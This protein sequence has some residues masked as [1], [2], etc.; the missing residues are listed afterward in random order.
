MTKFSIEFAKYLEK[1]NIPHRSFAFIDKKWTRGK[2]HDSTG[3]EKVSVEDL[4]SWEAFL[5][6]V[7][8]ECDTLII[9]SLPSSSHS[10]LFCERFKEML[11]LTGFKVI[12]FQH[13]HSVISIRRNRCLDEAI[14]RASVC[15]SHS[16]KN[17]FSSYID[18]KYNSGSLDAFFGGEEKPEKTLKTFQPAFDFDECR[19][20]YW[21]DQDEILENSHRWIGRTAHWKGLKLMLDWSVDYLNPINAISVM[22]G[23]ETSIVYPDFLVMRPHQNFAKPF[24]ESTLANFT[25]K[26]LGH[27]YIDKYTFHGLID[28]DNVYMPEYAGIG[29]CVFNI[30]NNH[31]MLQ[32]LSRTTYGYQLSVLDAKNVK[33]SVEYTH[34]EV[35]AAGAIPVFNRTFGDRCYSR[36]TGNPLSECKDTG[37]IWLNEDTKE[38]CIQEINAL[39]ADKGMRQEYREMSWEFYKNHQDSSVVFQRIM[40][41]INES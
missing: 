8:N 38:A 22:E 31:D 2:S 17:F 40:C 23:I 41:E 16:D 28:A 13:D 7:R 1:A 30:Y 12:L 6:E 3:I 35:V 24:T 18:E 14:E 34:C 4:S 9:N 25:K 15:Y 26:G 27:D 39:N 20:N 33:N 29:P 10:D 37:T 21:K 11:A 32:R 5:Q 19:D 36:D